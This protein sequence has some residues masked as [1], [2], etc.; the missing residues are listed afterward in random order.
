MSAERRGLVNRCL[1]FSMVDGPGNR[2]VVFLQGCNYDCVGCHNPHTINACNGCDVCVEACPEL[3]LTMRPGAPPA[4]D[5]DACTDCDRCVEECGFDS[6]PLARELTVAELLDRVRP[7][8]PFLSGITVSGGEATL[9]AG[10]VRDLFAATKADPELRHLTTMVDTNGSA[11]QEVWDLLAPVTDGFLVDLKAWDPAVHQR[12]TSAPIGPVLDSI[13]HLA[14]LDLLHE[15]RML[16]VGDEND[17]HGDVTAAAAWLRSVAPDV[18]VKMYGFRHHGTRPQAASL[19]EPTG[20]ELRHL[21]EIVR[22]TGERE[23][24]LV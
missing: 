10:F 23:V 24:V 14:A 17:R 19:R 4:L 7:H 2:F 1:P 6:T 9:Q 18:P 22:T 20:E 13:A 11:P 12:L 21:A 3:A 15:V 5:L 8:A 16:I